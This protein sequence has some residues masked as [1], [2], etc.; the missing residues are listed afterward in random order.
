MVDI[1]IGSTV[2]LVQ[3]KTVLV[4]LLWEKNGFHLETDV[5]SKKIFIHIFFHGQ[6]T[7]EYR[8]YW[9]TRFAERFQTQQNY[10]TLLISK[11]FITPL[12][13]D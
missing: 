13:S 9:S 5:E 12:T 11:E 7:T 4:Q 10:F 1:L 3:L 6:C 8:D 2:F